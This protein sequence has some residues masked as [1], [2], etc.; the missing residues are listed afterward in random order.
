MDD[1]A[2]R[3]LTNPPPRMLGVS[4]SLFMDGVDRF[5]W[6]KVKAI[7]LVRF[8]LKFVQAVHDLCF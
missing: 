7:K 8:G 5:C 4:R 6:T 1:I 2:L 3:R